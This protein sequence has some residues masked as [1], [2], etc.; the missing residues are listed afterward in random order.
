M[1]RTPE[2]VEVVEVLAHVI[3]AGMAGVV[4]DDAVRRRELVGRMREAGDHH[5]RH[6]AGPGEP[7]ETAG[8]T[9]EEIRVLDEVDAFLERDV[10]GEVLGAVG[11]VVPVQADAVQR[12]AGR[13]AMDFRGRSMS[14]RDVPVCVVIH[15]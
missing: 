11:D 1:A 6:L 10:A 14:G 15:A 9:D 12:R 7:G 2:E 5:D 4:V 3:P 13:A 8:E